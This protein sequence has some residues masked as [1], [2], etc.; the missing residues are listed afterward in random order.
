VPLSAILYGPD[1]AIVQVVRDQRVE[2]RRVKVGLFGGQDAE[3]REGVTPGDAVVVR[4]GAFLR[5]GDVVRA[6]P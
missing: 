1:G 4:A 6:V 2:T 3:I 5:E